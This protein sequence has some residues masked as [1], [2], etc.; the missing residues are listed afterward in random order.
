MDIVSMRVSPN[1]DT[2]ATAAI[3]GG[4][5]PKA[6]TLGSDTVS[7]TAAPDL[8]QALAQTPEARPEQVARATALVRD[9][10][11]PPQVLIQKLSDLFAAR[12]LVA[13][14]ATAAS[15]SADGQAASGED[16]SQ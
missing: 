13:P 12:I 1:S 11:Y 5:A 4:T 8:S 7:L 9:S 6:P 10:F 3:A 2:L 15:T 14:S 16:L